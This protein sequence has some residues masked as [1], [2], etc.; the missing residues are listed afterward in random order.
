MSVQKV[1]FSFLTPEC[2]SATAPFVKYKI[3]EEEERA[4]RARERARICKLLE[5]SSVAS[6]ESRSRAAIGIITHAH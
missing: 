4:R 6:Y 5:Q 1:R 3:K 2:Q